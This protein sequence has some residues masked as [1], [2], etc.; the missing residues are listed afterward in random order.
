MSELPG[1]DEFAGCLHTRFNVANVLPDGLELELDEVSELRVG[2]RQQSFSAVFSGP[3]DQ[4][5]PQHI[6]R[7]KHDRL[8]LLDLFLVPIARKGESIL[9]EAVF[10]RL[11]L[12]E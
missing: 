5:L 12:T 6:Y 2:Y 4:T 7:L 8:G 10:N 1:R 3:A 9:Y 11:I